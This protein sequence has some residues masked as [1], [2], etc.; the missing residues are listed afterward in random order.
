MEV[1]YKGPS[2]CLVRVQNSLLVVEQSSTG[3]YDLASGDSLSNESAQCTA[4]R[5]MWEQT[6]FNVEVGQLLSI[7]SNGTH[8]F[9]CKLNN[10]FNAFDASGRDEGIEAPAWN[11]H[12]IEAL[13]FV[14]PFDT[15]TENWTHPDHL[16]LYRDG[17]V[18][19]GFVESGV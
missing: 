13:R 2:A 11:K 10:G 5:N 6:G 19:V 9:A 4:H 17:Y 14:N 15:R 1:S 3:L 7:T 8:V 16:I 12:D 18:S